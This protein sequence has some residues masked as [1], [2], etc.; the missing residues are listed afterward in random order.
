MT[1]RKAG[2]CDLRVCECEE[3]RLVEIRHSDG[4]CTTHEGPEGR[5]RMTKMVSTDGR[6]VFYA[7]SR[8]SE[9]ILRITFVGKTRVCHYTGGP[10]QEALCRTSWPDGRVRYWRG[11]RN[12][13]RKT[14]TTYPNGAMRVFTGPKGQERCISTHYADGSCTHHKG[15]NGQECDWLRV[16]PEGPAQY[17][18]ASGRV[19][20]SLLPG[21]EILHHAHGTCATNVPSKN[22]TALQDAT[23]AALETLEELSEAGS[24]N[25][26]AL[27]DMSKTLRKIYLV[28]EECFVAQAMNVA[29]DY[30]SDSSDSGL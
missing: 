30:G 19:I 10:G 18:H 20:H 8:N 27:V 21:G 22:Y 7:G 23:R 12:C 28:A 2:V 5:E 4:T 14:R 26:V 11:A 1:K 29:R 15:A 13:E 17:V 6:E 16:Y 3:G 24:C 9:R 25:E